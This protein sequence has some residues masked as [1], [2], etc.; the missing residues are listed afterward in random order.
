MP[1]PDFRAFFQARWRYAPFPWQEMLAAR[2][3]A[4]RWPQALGLPTASGKSACINVAIHALASNELDR[5]RRRTRGKDVRHD[6]PDSRTRSEARRDRAAARRGVR[7]RTDLPLRLGGAR[8]RGPESDYDLL[9]IVPDEATALRQ[10]SDLAYRALRGTGIAADV[11]V[12]PRSRFESRQHVVASLPAT[13]L[14]EG[15]LLHA[16]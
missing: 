15:R 2:T 6:R 4:G 3:A 5:S 14:R 1:L 7:A 12:W 13:V 10:D 8:R 11:L 9:V 16:A